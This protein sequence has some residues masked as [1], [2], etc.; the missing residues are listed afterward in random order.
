MRII[1]PKYI[2]MR[3]I[4]YNTFKLRIISPKYIQMRII[5]PIKT[6]PQK[7]KNFPLD[8]QSK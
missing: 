8:R 7:C 5:S 1:S 6:V 2:Q 3:I 4:S